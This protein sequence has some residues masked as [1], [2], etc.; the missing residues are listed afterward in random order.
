MPPVTS[1][2]R[3][4]SRL[5]GGVSGAS[6]EDCLYLNVT[7]PQTKA[8]QPRPVV[9]APAPVTPSGPGLFARLVWA[10]RC[11]GHAQAAVLSGGAIFIALNVLAVSAY[12]IPAVAMPVPDGICE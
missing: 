4:L 12:S 6:S 5:G 10:L 9:A 7:V 2:A 8:E 11:Y 3:L 1:S